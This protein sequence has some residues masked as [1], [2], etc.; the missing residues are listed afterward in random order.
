[1]DHT[2]ALD[3]RIPRFTRYDIHYDQKNKAARRLATHLNPRVTVDIRTR[4]N[5]W[6]SG[7]LRIVF[8]ARSY[9]ASSSAPQIIH[10][11]TAFRSQNFRRANFCRRQE[12]DA[13]NIRIL[14]SQMTNRGQQFAAENRV[15]IPTVTLWLYHKCV[16]ISTLSAHQHFNIFLWYGKILW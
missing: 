10:K 15:R 12:A 8:L 3:C 4:R 7:A 11:F 16:N 6:I 5:A 14:A 13:V 2:F 9:L 1:M